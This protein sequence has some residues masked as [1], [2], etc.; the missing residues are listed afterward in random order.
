[1]IKHAVFLDFD[2]V[3]F[4]T[5]RESYCIS[6]IALGEA[7]EISGIDLNAKHFQEFYRHRYLIGPAWNYF[8]LMQLIDKILRDPLLDL[9]EI[10]HEAT[11]NPE[12]NKHRVFEKNFFNTRKFLIDNDPGSWLS[13]ITAYSFAEGMRVLVDEHPENFFLITTR[14]RSSAL[15]ILLVHQLGILEGNILGREE[16]EVY[17]SKRGVIQGLIKNRQIEES[18]FIDDLEDHLIACE[19][20]DKLTLVQACWGYVAP[21]KKEDNSARIIQETKNFIQGENVWT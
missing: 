20:I 21:E 10:F 11:R 18:I 13:L 8:Y 19:D 9:A 4:D 14:D 16:F 1:M 15:K 7:S 3:L 12:P 2:G 17:N 5:V 6:M